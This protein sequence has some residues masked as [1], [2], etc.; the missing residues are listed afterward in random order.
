MRHNKRK[1]RIGTSPAHRRSL[2]RNLAIE[3]IDHGKI[4]TTHAKCKAIQPY[5]EKLI[6]I[7]KEDS[8]ANRRLA[9]SK[10]GNAKAVRTLFTEVGPKYKE[11]D[12]GYTRILKLADGRVGDNA[13]MSFI[14][15]VD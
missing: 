3:V 6:T 9:L 8:V 2:L 15:L 12:G 4:K 11:R 13:K 14:A 5:V 7:S 10:L 1:Y